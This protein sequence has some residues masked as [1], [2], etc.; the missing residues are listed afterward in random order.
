[1]ES[2]FTND[3]EKKNRAA[4]AMDEIQARFGKK[5]LQKGFWLEEKK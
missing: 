5:A 1:M 2:L 4:K 3:R